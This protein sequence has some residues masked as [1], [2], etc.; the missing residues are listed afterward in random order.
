MILIRLFSKSIFYSNPGTTNCLKNPI[1]TSLWLS[2][3]RASGCVNVKDFI[4]M[5]LSSN[6]S[7]DSLALWLAFFEV[8]IHTLQHNKYP[9]VFGIGDVADLPTAKTVA[10]IRK[11][12][13]VVIDKE[14]IG[15]TFLISFFHCL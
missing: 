1:N 14:I 10:A 13:L 9:N 2:V 11:Q 12:V 5:L 8:N 6:V 3:S 15:L 4:G 7:A